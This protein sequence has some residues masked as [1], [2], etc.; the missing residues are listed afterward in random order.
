MIFFLAMKK[1]INFF[2]SIIL[3][4]FFL[5]FKF[6]REHIPRDIPFHLT[7]LSFFFLCILIFVSIYKLISLFYKKKDNIIFDYLRSCFLLLDYTI[8][9]NIISDN[10]L[11]NAIFKLYKLLFKYMKIMTFMEIYIKFSF[12]IIFIIDVFVFNCLS[13][14]YT[15]IF[16]FIYT[17]CFKYSIISLQSYIMNQQQML[18][19]NIEIR[20]TTLSDGIDIEKSINILAIQKSSKQPL[21]DYTL[22]LT[23]DFIKRTHKEQKLNSKQKI[24]IKYYIKHMQKKVNNLV[25]FKAVLIDYSVIKKQPFVKF[26]QVITSIFYLMCWFY[27]L[28]LSFIAL[29]TNIFESACVEYFINNDPFSEYTL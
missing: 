6:L 5:W 3:I 11:E 18:S 10:K 27:I 7:F 4:S 16:L 12:S 19:Q 14:I 20:T 24:N 2:I 22:L 23:Y 1:L 17:Y 9:K 21:F 28:Y 25:E 15:Y 13:Y 29:S 8:K 26:I